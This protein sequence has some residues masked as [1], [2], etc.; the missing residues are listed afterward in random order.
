VENAGGPGGGHSSPEV[1]TISRICPQQ[2]CSGLG[3]KLGGVGSQAPGSDPRT[4]GQLLSIENPSVAAQSRI[5]VAT[6]WP[7]AT[8]RAY[9]SP[10]TTACCGDAKLCSRRSRASREAWE[11]VG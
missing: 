3:L 8:E 4:Y 7:C 1:R 6:A 2:G 10:G 11:I 9:S 5:A